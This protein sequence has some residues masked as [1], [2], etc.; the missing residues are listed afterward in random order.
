MPWPS[1]RRRWG[2][3]PSRVPSG[4]RATTRRCSTPSRTPRRS[5]PGGARTR[6]PRRAGGG[7][8]PAI[9]CSRPRG[10]GRLLALDTGRRGYLYPA[11]QFGPRGVLPGIEAV[12]GAFDGV[13]AWT[14]A[15]WFLSG[16]ARLD[17]D[18]PLEALR[19]GEAEAVRRAAAAYGEQGAA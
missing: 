17:D 1:S 3:A 13:D 2:H 19:R 7:W 14:Q 9:G 15:A 18:T 16:D 6:S 11:W 10:A 4:R 8:K 12:L 5:R